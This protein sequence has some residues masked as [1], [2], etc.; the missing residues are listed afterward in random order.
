MSE[1]TC[2]FLVLELKEQKMCP[3]GI[4]RGIIEWFS[5]KVVSITLL[6]SDIDNNIS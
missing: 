2:D 1:C 6:P 5:K 4:L 3:F